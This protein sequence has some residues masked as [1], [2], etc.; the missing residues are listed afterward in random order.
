MLE[1]IEAL[2]AN[3]GLEIHN[4]HLLQTAFTHPSYA[5]ENGLSKSQNNERLEY[6]GDATLSLIIAEYL[7]EK[8]PDKQEGELS[9]I[10]SSI[11][12][13][14]SLAGFAKKLNLGDYLLLGKGEEQNGGRD[15]NKNLE[16]LYEAFLGAVFLDQGFERTKAFVQEAML[17]DVAIG[18][19]DK[20]TDYK[21]SLQEILQANGPVTIEYVVNSETG[22][23]HLKQFDVSVLLDGKEIGQGVGKSKKLAAQAAA[24]AAIESQQ[25]K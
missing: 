19:F 1:L 10:R 9:K 22:P 13:S 2:R 7:F 21:T 5:F 18:N 8:Y 15:R 11:V 14:E 25:G 20:V 3:Y 4:V 17:K 16:D 12:R 24:K 23:A 6:L